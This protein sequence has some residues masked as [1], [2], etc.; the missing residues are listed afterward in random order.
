MKR[1]AIISDTHGLLRP[2]VLERLR[3]ADA[4]LH[5][6]DVSS[7]DVLEE[8]QDL[9]KDLY[10]VRGNNDWLWGS[11][12]PHTLT[13]TIEG[14][15]FF[16]V[17][18]QRDVPRRLDGVDV[19]VYGHSHQYAQEERSGA[20]WLN[21]GSCGPRRLRQDITMAVMTVD[22]GRYQAARIDIPET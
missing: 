8:L 10:L 11:R 19:V 13:F 7:P 6:G 4:I 12:L 3:E 22:G 5:A 9:G 2:P 18:D 21:P 14:V 1:L 17:H 15:T 16:L 20:L